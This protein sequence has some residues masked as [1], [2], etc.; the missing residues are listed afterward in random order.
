MTRYPQISQLL[1]HG[2]A[3]RML[4]ELVAWQ[5][6][7]A[8]CAMQVRPTTRFVEDRALPSYT[9]LE[10]MAQ[11]IA[12]CLGYEAY[13]S[14]ANTR[15]GMIVSCRELRAHVEQTNVGDDLTITATRQAGTDSL[16]RFACEV[17]RGQELVADA[18]MTLVHGETPDDL[19]PTQAGKRSARPGDQ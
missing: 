14:G 4:D 3:V 16:S 15:V 18:T 17:R 12:A 8:V 9:L 1:S 5:P 13:R 7:R 10:P 2:E 6:G 11:S 19:A